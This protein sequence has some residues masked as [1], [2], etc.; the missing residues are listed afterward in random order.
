MKW[1]LA[2]AAAVTGVLAVG[3]GC[4]EPPPGALPATEAPSLIILGIDGMDPQLLRRYIDEGLMP[5]HKAL[6][7]AGGFMELGTSNPP[8]SPVAWS[9]FITGHR[10]DH[11]GIYDFVHRDPHALAPYLST[12]STA[13]P[14]TVLTLGSF[15]IPL[16]E[17]KVELLREGR[18]FWGLL[19]EAGIPAMV[20][21]I[22]A[23]F[24][25]KPDWESR[26]VSGMGTPDL[27]GT[28]GTFQ[29]LT[30][31]PAWLERRVSGGEIRPLTFDGVIAEGSIMGPPHPFRADGQ[32]LEAPV[33]IMRDPEDDVVSIQLGDE[34]RILTPGDWTDWLPMGFET[35]PL[36]GDV[37][38]MVRLHLRSVRPHLSLYVSPI[39]LDPSAPAMPLSSPRGYAAHVAEVTGRFYTQG[40]PEDTKA[41]AAGVL[42]DEAFLAQAR[43]VYAERLGLMR[44]QLEEFESGVMFFYFSSV[45]QVCHVFWRTLDADKD[46]EAS[47]DLKRYAGVIPEFYARADAALGEAMNHAK[48]ANATIIV[49][50]DHG[51]APYTRKVHLN[52]WLLKQGYLA[53]KEGAPEGAEF[54]DTENPGS[55]ALGHID[56]SRTQA[57]ALGLNQLFINRQGREAGGIVPADEAPVLLKR[58]KRSLLAMRDPE[59]GLRVITS[60]VPP[61]EGVFP[62]R[63]PDLLVGFNRGYRSSDESATGQVTETVLEDNTGKWSGDHCMDPRLVPGVFLSN[64]ALTQDT[65]HLTDVAPTVL[66][67]YGITPPEV[68]TGT[69]LI[70]PPSAERSAAK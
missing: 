8:Q 67:H 23:N 4:D 47:P 40:M 42:D 7:E 13:P 19:E 25:P 26:T 12:S 2:F 31:D 65:G 64:R 9:D 35:L 57:Y 53:L 43:S 28:Y 50:S 54:V 37:P 68:M 60:I 62:E 10:S 6:A 15:A 22:P 30:D 52:T 46:P 20:F 38:G 55:G 69:A 56:W 17:G 58:I 5:N 32:A 44:Q 45:D 63:A 3:T 29:L 11:H 39:N 24:P 36:T 61:P 33:Q 51:F 70:A 16:G 21:K 34:E 66:R 14:E 48:A 59:N 41:L 1:L 49:M 27:L 18:S